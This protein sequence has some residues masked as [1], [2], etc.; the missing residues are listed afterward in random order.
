[1]AIVGIEDR[2]FLEDRGIDYKALIRALVKN[3]EAGKIVQGGST[4]TQQ[5]S[6]N[7]YFDSK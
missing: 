5:L 7:L 4:I 1:M 6:K 3:I 2:R